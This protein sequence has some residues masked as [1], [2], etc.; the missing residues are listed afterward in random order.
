MKM[1]HTKLVAGILAAGTAGI[2]LAYL[3]WG[4]AQA[5][6]EGL[7]QVNGRIESDQVTISSKYPGRIVG[8]FAREGDSVTR[9]QLVVQLDDAQTRAQRDQAAADLRA[10]IAREQ[11]AG[12]GVTLT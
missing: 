2:A 5:L 8:L 11:G 3:H 10:A 12:V 1:R 4:Q 6:P 9:G 7:I